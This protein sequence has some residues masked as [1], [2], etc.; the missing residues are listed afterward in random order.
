M[1]VTLRNMSK[2]PA[3]LLRLNLLDA[4]GDQVLPV[5]YSDNYIHLMPGRS[6]TVTVEWDIADTR[7]ETNPT[8][9]LTGFNLAK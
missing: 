4:D 3:M 7:S 8:V 5:N 6:V 9:A 1:E 2:V